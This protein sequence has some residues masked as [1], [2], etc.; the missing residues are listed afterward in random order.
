MSSTEPPCPT[1]TD[2]VDLADLADLDR[3]AAALTA[4]LPATALI[5][6]EGDLGAGKTTLVKAVAAAAGI[7]PTE[8]TSPTFGLIHLH[9]TA[10]AS[11]RL[12]HGDMYRLTDVD[13]LRELGWEEL[14]QPAADHRSWTFV[15]W[16][17]RIAAAL[18]RERLAIEIAITGET[19]RRLNLT[20]SGIDYARIPIAVS[21]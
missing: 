21:S 9:D 4:A 17:Q 3:F 18:P 7:D 1:A 12:V 11:L 13:E 5:T 19:T 16:P 10:D 15:E 20:G 6:L 2:V 14:L 8:V